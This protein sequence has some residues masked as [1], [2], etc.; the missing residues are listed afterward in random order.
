M[1][2][3]L[4]HT[5]VAVGT[6]AGNGEIAKAQWNENHTLTMATARLLGR[7]TAGAGAVEEI[8]AGSNLS[9]SGG[10]LNL[11]STIALSG[12]ATLTLQTL[13]DA[14][15]IDWNCS[16]GAKAKVT[17]GGN[18]TMNAVTNA[19]EGTSYTLWVIQDGTGGRTLA[20]TTSGAGSFDFGTEGTPVL[21]TT[22]GAA[23]CLGF[24][25]ISIGGTLKLR[26]M[27]IKRGFS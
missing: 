4:T 16:S 11:A 12:Q 10:S 22:I 24:E 20:Y 15:N 6:D 18:R 1:A 19:V 23:D 25:A 9:L 21:T 3:S 27:G 2:I 17:L 26:F 5:T 14:A 13:T 8:S 7:T